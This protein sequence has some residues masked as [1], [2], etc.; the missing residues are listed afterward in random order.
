M[1]QQVKAVKWL[2][3]DK[4]VWFRSYILMFMYVCLLSCYDEETNYTAESSDRHFFFA[5][6]FDKILFLCYFCSVVYVVMG[7]SESYIS[8]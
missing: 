3:M 7:Y 2:K 8:I 6:Y 5:K 1:N 4:W